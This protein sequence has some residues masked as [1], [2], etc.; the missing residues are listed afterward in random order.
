M[1][2]E[3]AV[4]E[5]DTNGLETRPRRA[6]RAIAKKR[7]KRRTCPNEPA[8]TGVRIVLGT[9]DEPWKCFN[10]GNMPKSKSWTFGDSNAGP[11]ARMCKV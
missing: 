8:F 10:V 7:A 3:V 9:I 5:V 2:A 1:G 11:L 6:N 4:K